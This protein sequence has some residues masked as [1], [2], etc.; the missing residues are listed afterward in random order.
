MVLRDGEV[1]ATQ[2]FRANRFYQIGEQWFFSTREKLQV[3]PFESLDEAEIEL[4]LMLRHLKEGGY[5]ALAYR[6]AAHF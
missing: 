5:A 4:A 3:G 6:E 2:H 1:N